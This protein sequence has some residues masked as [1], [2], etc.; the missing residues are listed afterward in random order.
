M[1]ST[2]PDLPRVYRTNQANPTYA[3]RPT[4]TMASMANGLKNSRSFP[5]RSAGGPVSFF[6]LSFF[7]GAGSAAAGA[8]LSAAADSAGVNVPPHF[9]HSTGSS[10]PGFSSRRSLARQSGQR[11]SNGIGAVHRR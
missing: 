11:R 7:S 2:R 9:G 4:A 10:R 3:P 6:F 5:S 8:A 1:S